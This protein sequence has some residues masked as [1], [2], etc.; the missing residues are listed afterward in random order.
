MSEKKRV[1][2]LCT[3]NSARSQMAEGLLRHD[4]GDRFEVVSAGTR[5]EGRDASG[6]DRGDGGDRHRYFRAALQAPRMTFQGQAFDYVITVCDRARESCPIFPHRAEQLHWSFPDPAAAT[7]DEE[8]R[9]AAF[10]QVRDEITNKIDLFVSAKLM[11]F[12]PSNSLSPRERV[13]VR[14]GRTLAL[15]IFWMASLGFRSHQPSQRGWELPH[16]PAGGLS[17]RGEA[18][19]RNLRLTSEKAG[20]ISRAIY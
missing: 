15:D 7:G 16:P 6:G 18:V 17:P 3:G 5:A 8:R 20:A 14:E 4:A 1:L 12:R 10:R 2:I 19:A 9:L 13:R 11:T